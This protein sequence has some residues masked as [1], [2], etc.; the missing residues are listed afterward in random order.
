M[1][2]FIPAK[3]LVARPSDPS[4]WS[5]ECT[6]AERAKQ[7]SWKRFRV[8]PTNENEVTYKIC[9]S[10]VCAARIR[11]AKALETACLRRRLQSGSLQSKQWWSS[12]KQAGGDGRHCSIPVIR[13]NQGR[14]HS[15]SQ[16]KADCF[17][18][19]YLPENA[20]LKGKIL[21]KLNF[22]T[23]LTD[24]PQP[25]PKYASV[26]PPLNDNSDGLTLQRQQAMTVFHRE[27]SMC[28]SSRPPLVPPVF[29]LH[30]TRNLA[31]DVENC[32]CRSCP[33]KAIT[34]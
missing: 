34:L 31:I 28:S 21:N 3:R 12:V 10:A 13:D 22:P 33:Q 11:H 7:R 14:E 15:F 29:P 30:K 4:W 19:F 17:G 16:E 27:F 9:C 26:L 1:N 20:A 25:S 23:F 24:A 2:R 5:L 8:H 6:A 18:R 32:Q